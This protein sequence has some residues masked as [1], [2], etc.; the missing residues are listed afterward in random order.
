MAVKGVPLG[1]N[2]RLCALIN[3]PWPGGG[4]L[5]CPSTYTRTGMYGAWASCDVGDYV[6]SAQNNGD[7][8][9]VECCKL[10]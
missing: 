4:P 7:D 9:R 3:N 5:P 10:K 8:T 2:A 6:K 1:N